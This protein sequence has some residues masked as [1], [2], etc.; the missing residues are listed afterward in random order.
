MQI[1]VLIED[2]F[3]S[4]RHDR[5]A[6]SSWEPEI[7]ALAGGESAERIGGSGHRYEGD[8]ALTV[9]NGSDR[10]VTVLGG[11]SACT[12][13]C[14]IRLKDLPVR[15]APLSEVTLRVH[16]SVHQGPGTFALPITLF[17]DRA[18]CPEASLQFE[19]GV[20]PR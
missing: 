7:G 18:Q 17:T 12:R 15:I 16:L 8:V 4:L 14:C 5:D 19:G 10:P 1:K 6:G 3:L 13:Q 2:K 20:L 11:T 9:V